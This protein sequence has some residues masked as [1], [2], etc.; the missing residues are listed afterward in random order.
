MRMTACRKCKLSNYLM[1][2]SNVELLVSFLTCPEVF[3][4]RNPKLFLETLVE[5]REAVKSNCIGYLGHIVAV[6][7][8]QVCGALQADHP[9]EKAGRLAGQGFYLPIKMHVAVTSQP[10]ELIN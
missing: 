1:L 4:R 10:A 2:V 7:R 9:K 6:T 3:P 8:Q 5:I